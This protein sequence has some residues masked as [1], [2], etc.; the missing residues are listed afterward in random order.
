MSVN[1]TSI[2][3]FFKILI[4]VFFS[5]FLSILLCEFILRVKHKFLINY[6]IEMWKYAKKL[7]VKSS[8]PKINHTHKKNSSANLQEVLI[9][10]NNIGQRDDNLNKGDLKNFDRSF[11]VLGS[12]VALGWG[13]EQEKTFTSELNNISKK[14]NKNWKFVNGGIGNYNTERY[15]NNFLENWSDNKFTDIIIH[16]F[17]NDTEVSFI[18]NPNFFVK[19]THFGVVI[20]KLFNSYKSSFKK[21]KLVD[22]YKKKYED[23]FVGVEVAKKELSRLMDYCEKNNVDCHLIM[24]PDIHQLD[25]YE[26]NF[27]NEKMKKISTDLGY[28][29]FDLLPVFQN[30]KKDKIWNKYNDPH[31]S[32]YAHKLMADNIYEYLNK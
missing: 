32:A 26:L 5:I 30:Q 31:P 16:F 4:S 20:W 15:V 13:V 21:E 14:N 9:K 10:I 2:S 25:P 1:S 27:I 29:F 24:M 23:D 11:I 3:S 19:N 12:S 22:Y 6:D 8:N 28:K 17:V 18:N 7:K